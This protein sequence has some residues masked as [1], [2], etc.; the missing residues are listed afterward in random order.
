MHL[1]GGQRGHFT[2]PQ[3]AAVI[4]YGSNLTPLAAARYPLIHRHVHPVEAHQSGR[5]LT[6]V[7]GI[8]NGVYQGSPLHF[9]F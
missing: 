8:P 7:G 2:N 3:P 6:G 5:I 4:Y 9:Y 1:W